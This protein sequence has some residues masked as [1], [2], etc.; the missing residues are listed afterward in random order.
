[1]AENYL[2]NS[3][4]I[5]G[6]LLLITLFPLATHVVQCIWKPSYFCIIHEP[7]IIY[8]V[9]ETTKY[10]LVMEQIWNNG[11]WRKNKRY[12]PWLTSDMYG[13]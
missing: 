12:L 1:M 13:V 2:K 8:V 3:M 6:N 4:V 5:I 7:I 10:S 9:M 11:W